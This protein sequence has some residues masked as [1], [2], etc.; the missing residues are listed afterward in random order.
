MA[1][2]T[3]VSYDYAPD[4]FFSFP[5]NPSNIWKLNKHTYGSVELEI[6]NEK[7]NIVNALYR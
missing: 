2:H 3:T 5:T 7:Y 4:Y 6:A 1:V